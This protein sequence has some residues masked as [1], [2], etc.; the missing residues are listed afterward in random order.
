MRELW[1][2]NLVGAKPVPVLSFNAGVFTC[3]IEFTW[4]SE[5]GNKNPY[6]YY[7]SQ[8]YTTDLG[9]DAEAKLKALAN[10]DATYTISLVIAK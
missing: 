10:L 6:K 7:N 2:K 8:A 5:F 9:L 4:G 3:H 1:D